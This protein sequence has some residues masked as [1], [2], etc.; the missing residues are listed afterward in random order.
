MEWSKSNDL[1]IT[2]GEDCKYRIWDAFGRPIYSSDTH[3][4]PITNLKWSP[5]K[6]LF[7]V[8]AFNIIR[9]C[10]KAGV[11]F[12]KIILHDLVVTFYRKT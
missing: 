9:L 3:Y 1:I 10:D 6:D 5:N 12:E 8:G 11:G 7:V 4:Y 2:G